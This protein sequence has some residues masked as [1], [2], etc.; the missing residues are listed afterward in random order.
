[1]WETI[2]ACIRGDTIRF[3]ARQKIAKKR[4]IEELEM[5]IFHA[6]QDRDQ[7]VEHRDLSKHYS[8]KVSFL[9]VELEDVYQAQNAI[10]Q[11]FYKARKYYQWERS[12]KYYFWLPG[13]KQDSIKYLRIR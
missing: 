3:L 10:V 11:Q 12:S 4:K 13:K 2:K 7:N 9:Q 1:M 6:V 5:E 8:A